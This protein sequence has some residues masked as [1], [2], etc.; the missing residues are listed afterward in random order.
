MAPLPPLATPMVQVAFLPSLLSSVL[1]LADEASNPQLKKTSVI[2]YIL[3]FIWVSCIW[4]LHLSHYR[5]QKF[6]QQVY[7]AELLLKQDEKLGRFTGSLYNC[8]TKVM[9]ALVDCGTKCLY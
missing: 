1:Q 5:L 7:S 4:Q 9:T 8:H 2:K 6:S 3:T